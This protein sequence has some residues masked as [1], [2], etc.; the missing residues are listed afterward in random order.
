[1]MA[2]LLASRPSSA[3]SAGPRSRSSTRSP[4]AASAAPSGSSAATT[5]RSP[6]DYGHVMLTRRL[7][8]NDILVLVTGC[9]AVANGKAGQMVP[10]GRGDGGSG[11]SGRVRG[12][13]H[14]AGAAH[15]LVRGQHPDPRP[16]GGPGQAPRRRHRASSRSPA[17]RPS[18]TPRRPSRSAPTSSRPAITTVLGVQ[19]PIFGSA[20]VVD[21]LANGLEGVVGAKF[22]VEPDP[23]KA[24]V[25][26]RRHIEA[27][28]RGPRA[29]RSSSRSTIAGR[30]RSSRCGRDMAETAP[31]ARP[32]GARDPATLPTGVGGHH[33]QGR[34]RQDHPERRARAAR[35]PARADGCWPSTPT[36]SS[37]W[38][39]RWA[40]R[41][42]RPNGSSRSAATPTTSRRRRAPAPAT[43]SGRSCASTR[44]S[45]TSSSASGA[46]RPTASGCSSWAP[47]SGAGGAACAPRTRSSPRR[48]GRSALRERGHRPRH[49]GRGRALRAG[50][51]ARVRPCASW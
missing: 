36:R 9:A 49:P 34:R 50:P 29:C 28:R 19:P 2:R 14:P 47:S 1:M 6:Q 25:L 27:K 43:A 31:D 38:R 46:A 44:I 10:D 51:R 12:A 17:P 32:L 22:A 39:R 11:P 21:L 3:P 40:S 23:E 16:G 7:I 8:E 4:R 24:A 48:S 30:P 13:R 41:V 37:T 15:G 35:S 5:P 18:G 45:T 42:T 33:R 20:N 26:I